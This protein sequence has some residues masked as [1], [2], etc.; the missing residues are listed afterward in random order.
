MVLAPERCMLS[1]KHTA[2]DLREPNTFV[3][4]RVADTSD[5]CH[6]EMNERLKSGTAERVLNGDLWVI[7]QTC[8]GA[9]FGVN[10]AQIYFV[11]SGKRFVTF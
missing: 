3:S 9:W 10:R 8:H 1:T 5:G 2:L 11:T 4:P 6:A 7:V